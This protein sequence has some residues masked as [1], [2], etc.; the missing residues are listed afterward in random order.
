M[1]PGPVR[2]VSV[3]PESFR[4]Y[5][6]PR[7]HGD[8]FVEPAFVDVPEVLAANRKL[9]A[10]YGAPFASLRQRARREMID[11]ALRYTS[12][13]RD[14]SWVDGDWE[15]KGTSI[16]MAGHQPALFHPGVWFKNFALSHLAEQTDSIAVNLVVDNDVAAGSSVRIPTIDSATGL[17]RGEAVAYDDAGGGVPYEQTTI[18]NRETFDHFDQEVLRVVRSLV[19]DPCVTRVW[20]HA[21]AAIA[22]CGV[23]GCALAQARHGLE[24]EIGL[25]TLELPLGV[26]CRSNAFAEFALSILMELPRFVQCYND[27][28]DSYRKAHGI[29]STAHPVPNLSIEDEWFEAP[30]W[31]YGNDS[32]QRQPA[33]VKLSG[34]QLIISDRKDRELKVDTRFPKLAAEQLANL[35]SPNF[36]LRPRALLTTMYS[37]L[38]LSDLFLHGIG[39]GKYDQL[40]DMIIGSFFAVEPPT[41]MVISA[42]VQLPE[43]GQQD[44]KLETRRLKREIRDSIYQPERFADQVALSPDLLKQKQELISNV[45]V[46]GQ[47]RVW[48]EQLTKVNGSLSAELTEMREALQQQLNAASQKIA[49]QALLASREHPFCVFPLDYLTSTY[50]QLLTAE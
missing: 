1:K 36:K 29:R 39:G 46:R 40:G 4:Q 11:S 27:A 19:P 5:R 12:A 47:R 48:H 25:K 15:A 49:S 20:E 18:R 9:L 2:A 38:V 30:M 42:T 8:Q 7:S 13:Y 6:A 33:W 34:D 50:Q 22:R 24:G 16:I 14:V 3:A 41:F 45:P 10:G 28:A 44:A 35:V 43:S 26:A 21:R 37:R 31:I 17:I 23:A 32:P